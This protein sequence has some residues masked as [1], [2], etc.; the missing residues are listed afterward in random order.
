MKFTA[1][2]LVMLKRSSSSG[3]VRSRRFLLSPTA[4]GILHLAQGPRE[5]LFYLWLS[6]GTPK[7]VA[8]SASTSER[9]S[10]EDGCAEAE[11]KT[12]PRTEEYNCA[13]ATQNNCTT[14]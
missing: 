9:Q 3:D 6:G 11:K 8:N 1:I 2:L 7:L 5:G 4:A 13:K 12:C 14:Y 10:K